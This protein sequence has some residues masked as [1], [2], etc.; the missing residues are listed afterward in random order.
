VEPNQGESRRE[1]L[2]RA[3]VGSE[4]FAKAAVNRAWA[5]LLGHGVVDPWDDLGGEGAD[6]PELLDR[7]AA[8]FAAG[9]YDLKK[10][11]KAIVLSDAYARSARGPESKEA[12]A[13]FARAPLRLLSADQLFDSLLVATGLERAGRGKFRKQ[14]EQGKQRALREYLFVFPD[15]EMAE[16]DT[17]MGNVTQALLLWNGE[18]TNL[19]ALALEGGVLAEIL[20]AGGDRGARLEAMFLAAYARRPTADEAA[21]LG[22]WLEAQGDGK[23]AY[24]DLYFAMLTSTEFVTNH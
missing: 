16:V 23:A 11:Y 6:H 24:E 18:V 9:G 13:E 17:D 8:E 1:T 22:A 14:V 4:L 15:D 19:G 12:T 21:R 2:A 7:L 20:A 5:S 10:L 3:M